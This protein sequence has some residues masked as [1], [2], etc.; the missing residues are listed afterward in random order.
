MYQLRPNLSTGF[1]VFITLDVI[2]GTGSVEA[3]VDDYWEDFE[4]RTTEGADPYEI[5][6]F[7]SLDLRHPDLIIQAPVLDAGQRSW[8]GSPHVFRSTERREWGG[9]YLIYSGYVASDPC[10]L[11]SLYVGRTNSFDRRLSE[12]WLY[13]TDVVVKFFD[14]MQGEALM[15]SD[16]VRDASIFESDLLPSGILWVAMWREDSERE[17]VFLEHELTFKSRPF[18]N[19][20]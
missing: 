14:D 17:R 6:F 8:R 19:R 20:N 9:C 4:V 3:L 13:K 11:L 5:E 18:Y 7:N 1:A 10:R 15:R 2:E 12:H 16:I